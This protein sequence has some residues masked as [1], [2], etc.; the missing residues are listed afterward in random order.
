MEHPG[1][2][3]MGQVLT[4]I[5]PDRE[6]RQRKRFYTVILAH[7][8][9]HYWFGDYVTMSWWDDTWLN[10]ALG[11][12]LDPKITD[13]VE[14]SWRYLDDI[15][16]QATRAMN[17]DELLATQPIIRPVD[18]K[19]AIEASFDADVTYYKGS[20]VL[21]MFEHWVGV[22]EFQG[23][24]RSWVRQ[25]AWGTATR[26]AFFAEFRD[27]LGAD[28][29]AG[30]R[31][32][33]EQPGV[34]LIDHELL[35]PSGRATL[36]LRQRRALPA[37][38]AAAAAPGW[39]LP[40]CV[41]HG[42]GRDTT[43]QC[44]FL[45]SGEGQLALEGGACPS[46]LVINADARVYYRSGYRAEELERLFPARRPPPLSRRE[47]LMTLADLSAGIERA[48]LP[49]TGGLALIPTLARDP[50][51]RIVARARELAGL[52]QPRQLDDADHARY[53]RFSLAV[54]GKRARQLGWRRG[55][56]DSDERHELRAALV[57]AVA[58]SGDARLAREADRLARAWLAD[59]AALDEDLVEPALAVA[60]RRGD[61]RLFDAYV[62][63]ARHRRSQHERA[64]VAAE[65]GVFTDPALAER[66]R[67]AIFGGGI[68][69]RDSK[70]LIVVQLAMRENHAAAWSWMEENLERLVAGLRDDEAAGMIGASVST[71]CDAGRRQRAVKLMGPV[72]DR[73]I[74]AR[75]QLD[76]ALGRVDRCIAR[77]ARDRESVHEFLARF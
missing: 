36:R 43:R 6:T 45:D 63:A 71:L 25:H 69:L 58:N 37:G 53:Q 23:F 39:K 42:R 31:S 34:P 9:A 54:F 4:L 40:V 26:E 18:S 5:P 38:T 51:D 17:G 50:D 12:W 66:A 2:V 3:A 60:A 77:R 14:P 52:A 67:G 21:A 27:A 61:A 46:W 57:G 13:A 76:K 70:N 24:I 32:F 68:D 47:R 33:L 59:R 35:C 1:I 72:A 48:E 16:S 22:E 20:S 74:G 30:L 73:T 41:R 75:N 11:Q 44:T 55:P 64:L 7:E 29:E 19:E 49:V 15:V 8:L 28:A 62:D 56:G 65:L 10:E